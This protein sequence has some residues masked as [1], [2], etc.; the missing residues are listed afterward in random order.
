[1]LWILTLIHLSYGIPCA[2]TIDENR[3]PIE[4][5]KEPWM[6]ESMS[7]CQFY[8]KSPVCCTQA[9]D[10]GIAS[11]FISLDAT[12]GSDGDGS[13]MKR[14]WCVYS[15]DPRQ[16]EFLQITGR[17][18]VTD[19][20]NPNR[21]IDVQTVTLRIHPQVACDVFSSCQRTNFASQVSAMAT[22]G[23]FFNFQAEQGV[24]SSLQLIAIEFSEQNSLLMPD[25]NNC[26]QTFEKANDGKFY[27]PYKFEIKQPCGC[28]T[29][30]DSCDAEKILYQ[31]PGVFYGF[32]WQY[33]LFAWGWA[34]LFAV[35]FTLYRQ[36]IK[37][38][39]V[40]QEDE[41]FIYN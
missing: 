38:N 18:N 26:N 37:K 14:F 19:P 40:L 7:Q 21:T 5:D 27:D 9:Q 28:N 35:A 36:C 25:I 4:T 39:V 12:F 1:M 34:I 6:S 20:R 2:Y 33:V 22:P 31:E 17:A 15:C 24:S 10:E 29:C 8:E 13:N 41:D 32:D 16:G 11:D 23:G 30:E 3:I